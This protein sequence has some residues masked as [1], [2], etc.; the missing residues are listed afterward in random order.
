M[1]MNLS[2]LWEMVKDREAWFAA[3]HGVVKSQTWLSDWTTTYF[4]RKISLYKYC[5][6]QIYHIMIILNWIF[7][8]MFWIILEVY[9]KFPYYR[10]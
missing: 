6:L 5:D 1:G 7:L 8:N 3:V 2:K 9:L 4:A 10:V